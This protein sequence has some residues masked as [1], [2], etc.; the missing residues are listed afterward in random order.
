MV[1]GQESHEA[2][3][4][5]CCPRHHGSHVVFDGSYGKLGHRRLLYRCY[6]G[7][8]GGRHEPFHRFTEPLPREA[9]ES[10][11]CEV[12][13]RPLGL[14]DGPHAPR[15]H[16]Y[17]ARTIA[18][19]LVAVGKGETYQSASWRARNGAGRFPL[20]EFGRARETAHGQLV[21]DWVEVFAPVVFEAHRPEQWPAGTLVVD[22]VPFRVKGRDPAG[23]PI[24][25][26]MVAFN[27]LAALGY[28]DGRSNSAR[29]NRRRLRTLS[30]GRSSSVN[31]AGSRIGWSVTRMAASQLL[32]G[33]SGLRRTS[34]SASGTWRKRCA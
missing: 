27:V 10:G 13:E 15:N 14:H 21:G 33:G 22:H 16:L 8:R 30:N 2:D 1:K 6:P 12:C 26:G 3:F 34:A 19:A 32:F 5:P 18:Q 17:T 25:G 11:E 7:G 31:S 20:T 9:P 29:C 28:E 23:R 4:K 24:P